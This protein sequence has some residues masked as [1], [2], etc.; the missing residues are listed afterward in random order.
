MAG[1]GPKKTSM[2]CLPGRKKS[3]SAAG[4]DFPME[5]QLEHLFPA[6]LRKVWE[7]LGSTRQVIAAV[8]PVSKA[9]RDV[10]FATMTT[11][12]LRGCRNITDAAITALAANCANLTDINLWG[13]RN[14]TDAAMTALAGNCANLTAVD[15][16]NCDKIT[17]AAITAL[18]A[19]CANLTTINLWGCRNITDA[20]ITALAASCAN[21]TTIN[22]SYCDNITNAAIDDFERQLPEC[23]VEHQRLYQI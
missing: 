12:N 22:L 9:L 23:E 6:L 3:R 18:A 10:L 13:C 5:Q 2:A 20:A 21:L 1:F 8:T 17:D 7:H 16:C 4:G 14:I 15:L 11:I 19:N